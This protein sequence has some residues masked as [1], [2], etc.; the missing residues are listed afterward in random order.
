M[1]T[2]N[3]LLPNGA[4]P[5]LLTSDTPELIP[6]DAAAVLAY[7]R[8]HPDVTP[9]MIATMLFR[10]RIA[11]KHRVL[12]MV[13]NREEMIEALQTVVD[14]GEH[15]LVMRA[16]MAATAR[17][18]AYV[19]PGQ[20]SQRPGMG[21]RCYE[22]VPAFRTEVERCA[23]AFADHTGLSP[24]NYLLDD[25]FPAPDNA[26]DN[27]LDNAI[28]NASTVQPALFTQMAG[29]AAMWRSFGVVPTVTIGHSQGEIAAAY[30]SGLITLT[31]AV[32]VVALRARAA[33]G[34]AAGDYAMAVLA[35]DRET[36]EDLLARCTGWAQL[37]VINSPSM[38]AISGD[39][40]AVQGIV[41]A[42]TA[43]DIF[44]RVIRVQYPAHTSVIN[45]LHD[46][47]CADIRR[48]LTTLKFLDSD[49]ACLGATLGGPLPPDLAVDQYWF[50][51]LRN[52][53]R[54]DKAI[55]A[56]LPFDIDTYVELAE[57][58]TLQLAI[59]EN[60]AAIDHERSCLVVG[61]S[62]RTDIDLTDFTHNVLRLALH[63]LNYSWDN[64]ATQSEGPAP[65]PLRDFPNT[66]MN[67]IR[68]WIPYE[69][70]LSPAAR[71]TH[72]V[73]SVAAEPKS[74]PDTPAAV[75]R[76]LTEQWVRLSRRSLVPPRAVGIIDH[77]GGAAELAQALSVA[78]GEVGAAARVLSA[79][80]LRA[81]PCHLNTYVI[82]LPQSPRRDAAGSVDAVTTF[83]AERSWWAPPGDGVTDY[84]LVTVAGEAVIADDPPPDPVHAAASAGFRCVG[85]THP[86][87]RF[88][89]LDLPGAAPAGTAA[90]IVAALHTA[91]ESE[92]ALRDGALYAKR[93]VDGETTGSDTSDQPADHVLIVGG[94]GKLGLE[95]CEHF[96]SRGAREIT[97]VNRSGDTAAVTERLRSIRSATSTR[98]RV[99][100]CDL[101]DAAAVSTLGAR[102]TPA[103]LI[104]HAAVEYSG[105]ELGDITAAAIYSAL[106]AKVV[107]IARVLA[108]FPRSQDCRV[109]LCSSIS[110]SVG[111][112]GLAL[113]AAGNRMLDALA[114]R[115]R[116]EGLHCVSVQWGHWRV[117]LDA[118]GSA[119]LAGLGVVPMR[120]ADAL[121]VDVTRLRE[122]TIVAAF[123]LDRAR[124]VLDACGRGSLLSQLGSAAPSR[125]ESPARAGEVQAGLSQRLVH[126]LAQ[127]I[128]ADSPDTIDTGVPMV[129]IGLDSLQALEF[130]R[131]VKIELNRDL[132]IADLLGG[133][134]IAEV[135]AKLEI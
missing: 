130:R 109:V 133:A 28:D 81:A 77:T 85:A 32:R 58:P 1:T 70:G 51:N 129:A 14:G 30:V 22:S 122:N 76:L 4:I 39:R 99:T 43:R 23:R 103:D 26:L 95:F 67:E 124:S 60:L 31:D 117:H 7:V 46:A 75:P 2:A 44:A 54:F 25:H 93:V 17:R 65:L 127:A 123:D 13:R 62:T 24:L 84:W 47:L 63:D 50:F 33:D 104:I 107:G 119:M 114:R 100:A 91:E 111:G 35:T 10:T 128:G 6:A 42:C 78:A 118:S 41:D 79:D 121:A 57:H 80:E 97:L 48:E 12:A 108:A 53:V 105:V 102:G 88:R 112:R 90:A 37:S 73:T 96:A 40:K 113:Y 21:R 55:A 89:H 82:L 94:T 92:L 120:P 86:G 66:P 134:S 110:A 98:I 132:E 116:S 49:I 18:Y 101:T 8:D 56:A 135:L 83:F 87:V 68:L 16:D 27:A 45:T 59:Q 19:F 38:K 69:Q 29:L 106:Q 72:A 36:C 71:N 126:L 125:I 61:T 5:V 15:R 74:S 20:G 64:L 34:F 52:A 3:Y 9:Q 131:Q 11:R 115:L